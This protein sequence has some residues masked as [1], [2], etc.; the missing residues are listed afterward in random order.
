MDSWKNAGARSRTRTK[1]PKRKPPPSSPARFGTGPLAEMTDEMR[2]DAL[3]TTKEVAALLGISPHTV[4]RWRFEGSAS[5]GD[6]DHL[7]YLRM[8][9][10]AIRYK[11]STV[12]LWVDRREVRTTAEERAIRPQGLQG[13]AGWGDKGRRDH[14]AEE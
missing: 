12:R 13:A 1:P 8:R 3:L 10:N 5:E 4:A 11:A 2:A 9:N 14:G 7:P 6:V